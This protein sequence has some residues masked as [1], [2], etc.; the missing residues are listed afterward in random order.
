MTDLKNRADDAYF[1]SGRPIMTDEEYDKLIQYMVVPNIGIQPNTRKTPL[2]VWMGSLTKRSTLRAPQS[3]TPQSGTPQSGTLPVKNYIIQEKLDGVSCLYVCKNKIV[4][5]YTRGDGKI[6]SSITH[7]LKQNLNIP[8]PKED[9]MVRGELVIQRCI[10]EDKYKQY[11]SNPR[12]MV[13]GYVN[14]NDTKDPNG[15]KDID[16]V[17]Y[18]LILPTEKQLPLDQQL[19]YLQD[20][21]FK[22]VYHRVIDSWLMEEGALLDYLSRRKRKSKYLIDGLVITN[23]GSYIRNIE[24]NPEYSFAF[25]NKSENVSEAIVD[26]VKW[27]LSK[28]GL[29]KPQIYILPIKLENVTISSL[30]G[31]NAR[32]ILNNKIGPGTKLLIT[33]SGGV[34]PHVLAVLESKGEIILPPNSKF[35]NVDL[36]YIGCD[37]PEIA[38][39]QLAHFFSSIKAANCKERTLEKLYTSG[40]KTVEDIVGASVQDF[41]CVGKVLALKIHTSIQTCISNSTTIELLAALNAFGEGIGLKK[42]QTLNLDNPEIGCKGIS[43]TAFQTKI[44]PVLQEQLDRVRRL[45]NLVDDG[46]AVHDD[47]LAVHDDGLAVHDDGLAVHDDGLAVHDDRLLNQTFVFTGFRDPF[48]ERKIYFYGGK[49]SSSVSKKTSYLVV[50]GPTNKKSTKIIK[51]ENLQIPIITKDRLLPGIS[52]DF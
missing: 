23:P 40:L 43:M 16:F 4:H 1:N 51:A 20:A 2:P 35:N 25:K 12:N 17:A 13:S 26:N 8:T 22:T 48:L 49:V 10:F 38:I 32:F 52:H 33:R 27:N 24:G 45:K 41:N 29:Y 5:L 31:F 9:I 50:D 47:G 46:L 36:Y 30:T 28:G 44:L 21:G 6:G 18:E 34:I 37:S 19:L 7:L 15:M 3:G 11:F 42:L 39:K 14:K